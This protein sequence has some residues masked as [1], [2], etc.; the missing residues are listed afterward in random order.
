MGEEKRKSRAREIGR[1][2]GE[3]KRKIGEEEKLEEGWGRRRGFIPAVVHLASQEYQWE[4]AWSY[5]YTVCTVRKRLFC[6]MLTAG[7]I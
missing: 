7:K 4:K 2:L 5:R 1:R 6:Q 3:E